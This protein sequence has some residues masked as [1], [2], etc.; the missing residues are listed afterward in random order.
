M[1]AISISSSLTTPFTSQFPSPYKLPTFFRFTKT[2]HTKIRILSSRSPSKF[3]PLSRHLFNFS[4]P[5]A[6]TASQCRSE[7]KNS[8]PEVSG[9]LKGKTESAISVTKTLVYAVFCIAVSFSPFKVPAIAATVASEVKLDNKGRE[10]K[11]EVVFKEKDHEYADYTRRLLETVSNLLKIVEEVRGGNGDVKRAK[12]ALKEVKMRKEELQ[13]EI[14]SGMYTE[15]RELRLEKEKLVKRVG[16]IIDEVLMVQTEIESLKGEKVGVEELLD[17]I[18]TMEREYDELWERVGEIDDKMLRRETVA[19]SIGVRELC[20]I[21]RECEEL[22]KR[23]SREMRRRSIESSQENSVTKLSRSDIREELESAQ[24]KHLEQM[25]L[26]SIVEVE[27]LGPL[28]YQDSLDF[29]LRIKQ[30]LKDS[31]ELQRNLEARIRKNMKKLG[32]E[33]RFVVRTPEDEVVKG[34]PEVELK[35][36]FGDKEVVV[37]KAIGLH[38]YHGWKAWREEAK[39]YLKRRLIEDVDFGKQYVA[40][41]QECILLDRDRV[42]S[43][44]WYNE[45][46]SRWEMDPVAVPYAV[47]NKIVESARIRHDWGAMYLSLKG[48]DKEFYVD[49]KEFEVLFE[50]FGGFDELYM[51]MLACGIPTAVHVMRIPFSELDF[52]QQFLLIV[53]LAYLSLNGLWKTGTVSFWRDLILENVRNTNDDI[54]MMIVF[55][56]L[57][58]II[59]Y[60]VRMK[61]GMAWPQYMDQSVG[62]TWYLGW[63]SEVEMSFNSRKTDDLNW[64]IWFLIRTAVYG[65]VLFHILR[66]MKR[67]IPRLLGF[68]PMR[69]DPNF[70]KLRRVKAYFNYR[71]RRIKRKKKAGIDPIKNAFER[72]KRVK[73]P[74]IPLKDF[75]SVESMREEINEVVAF[76]QNPSAFQEMGARAPRGVLIVGERGTGKTSLALAI[77]AEARVPVV[78]VEA[79]E[80]EAG[81][82]VGQ[83]AS[84]VREL[85][86]TARDLAPVI[87][88][89]EDFD[90]FAGVRGQFI[91][92]K[93]QD[94]ESFINQLLV[95][96]DG[97][98][99]QDG[100][101]LMA[102]TRNIKQIDEALQRPEK[103]ALLRPIELK[104]VP[105]ALE[106]SAFR[107]KFLD[108]DELMS[109][110]GWFATFSGVVPKWF[111]KTK[112]VKKISRM[113]VDHLG[114]TLTKEDL[115]NVVDLMEPYGQISN[116]IELLTPPLD[117]TRETKL[118]HAVWAAGRGLIALLLPNF[119]TVDNLW[120]EPCA[121]EGIGCTKITKVEKEGS[122]SGNPESRSYLEKKLVFCFGSYVAAQLL[123][124]FGEE[125]LLSSSEIK[126]AQEI[127]TRMVLQYGWGPDD[128]PAIYYSSNAAAAMSMGNNH[129]YEMATKVEKVY[130]L[131]YYKAKEMLQK[132]RKVL[133]KVVEELLEYEI[134]TGKDLERLMDSNGGIREKEPFFLSKVDYQEGVVL[135]LEEA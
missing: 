134:L 132:N 20:F 78:N 64:S 28:F 6:S 114:L 18:G 8:L 17:M 72:M 119:D 60:S 35:W 52:Y 46:K 122:M 85:F 83:S 61:L 88:F 135:A 79:Q 54:M 107:S 118:P 3:L 23:F 68:G 43:K 126:Q 77:A 86:Q 24:R 95:E 2:P 81:L 108:T 19:M 53:R 130:D 80:L 96:L 15:L 59:P 110:C 128:S 4:S 76:L 127:A 104:L 1:D 9:T 121:W 94:H 47:S 37:P 93:Q 34:F 73:N 67:K 10:I 63:Q 133:E 62:S 131:A 45:D 82:W 102:T 111:R 33:K 125:N 101:V 14:M 89:V 21:E 7:E 49:I 105:V 69:R 103:T 57:D 120:L 44:T 100:V 129:E 13:D 50:D 99:K 40:Q 92:T 123:L 70:R 84:N 22:V 48:D 97:F 75:A 74:P 113:L 55:P 90:L 109:Y 12:L 58:C 56:L 5:A 66:F 30:C 31:R 41:R 11:T 27:D 117:W 115:Q 16:K 36:M 124:P 71:V 38:L 51:K 91:H 87:I 112:I 39:A 25:I 29:A 26:P 116:G 65:Y 32:N 106:G 98:E 42:V